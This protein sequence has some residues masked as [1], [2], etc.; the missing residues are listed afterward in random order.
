MGE[1]GKR[2]GEREGERERSKER[3]VNMNK[4]ESRKHLVNDFP[5]NTKNNHNKKQKN[6]KNRGA[7]KVYLPK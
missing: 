3:K 6:Q 4:S 5:S 2:K 7:N 1:L